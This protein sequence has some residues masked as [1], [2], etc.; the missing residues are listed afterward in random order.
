M[1]LCAFAFRAIVP[2]ATSA[3]ESQAAEEWFFVHDA[4]SPLLAV[5]VGL[6]LLWNRLSRAPRPDRA[7]APTTAL[8][9]LALGLVIFV[10]SHRLNTQLLLLTSLS[11]H[12]LALACALE[13]RPGLRQAWLPALA[14]L[15]GSPLP[16]SIQS[17][18]VWS[19]QKWTT[20]ASGWLLQHLGDAEVVAS[21]V[22]MFVGER[23]FLVIEAC[24]GLRGIEI[25]TT[26]S[27][28][29][30]EFYRG[31]G[32]RMWLVVVAAPFLAFG[33]NL[34]RVCLIASGP[35]SDSDPG[36]VTQGVG[37]VVAGALCLFALARILAGHDPGAAGI[38][39]AKARWPTRFG[40][41]LCA[42][43]ALL[44]ALSL[45]PASPLEQ[46][47]IDPQL[48]FPK[49]GAAWQLEE[50]L[51]PDRLFLGSLPL[52]QIIERRYVHE[53]RQVRAQRVDLF[54]AARDARRPGAV[55]V[56][57]KLAVPGRDWSLRSSE[58]A[59][60]WAAGIDGNLTTS[61]RP[62]ELALSFSFWVGDAHAAHW[63]HWL[64]VASRSPEP[65]L[66]YVRLSA[67][68]AAA[69]HVARER[70]RGLIERFATDF[71]EELQG[72]ASSGSRS[73]VPE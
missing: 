36:H 53:P 9:L 70:A 65:P 48:S 38:A 26:L 25:L 15:L 21:G 54:I 20:Q 46:S 30:R 13:G 1:L 22:T 67:P 39:E 29:T 60:L 62:G 24:S 68:L 11:A 41:R 32:V 64:G 71:A 42:W 10:L 28:V 4:K 44:A 73:D 40:V 66:Y 37:V 18:L 51:K 19:L 47:P 33:L 52:R 2:N 50:D 61:G 56:A 27:L 57:D 6:W 34:V 63:T 45:I 35:A 49:R 14:I 72:L 12:V 8:V 69:G 5:G 23:A 55:L 59:R 17:E 43:G 3:I 58:P 31:A 16:A 7:A